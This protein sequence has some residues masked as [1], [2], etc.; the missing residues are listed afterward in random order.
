VAVDVCHPPSVGGASLLQMREIFAWSGALAVTGIALACSNASSAPS[1]PAAVLRQ[2][3]QAMAGLHSVSA[4]VKFGPGITVEGLALSSATSK[5]QLPGESDSVFKVKQ[6][7][8]LLDLRVVTTGGHVYL[9]LPF[10]SFTEVPPAQAKQIPDVTTLFD[11][12]SGLPA[13]LS[14]GKDTRYLG[15]EQVEGTDSD[16]VSTTYSADQLGQLLG[17]I[18]PAGD[19]KATIWVGRSDHYVRKVILSGPL[20]EAGKV[21][22]VEVDL[23]AFNQAVVIA[24]PSLSPA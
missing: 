10:A 18:K 1:D 17:G 11:L 3:A 8:F 5:I 7:D 23:R 13:V 12:H 2:A 19:V 22:Q 15:M 16:K 14:A 24:T 20:V 4:D 6:G 9:R 21:V